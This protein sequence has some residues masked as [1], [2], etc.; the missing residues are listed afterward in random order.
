MTEVVHAPMSAEAFL[1]WSL[2]QPKGRRYE[3]VSGEVVRIHSARAAHA[4]TKF[5]Q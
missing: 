5:N 2:A 4:R 1:A 3:L